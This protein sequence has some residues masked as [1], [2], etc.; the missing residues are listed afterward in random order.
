[1]TQVIECNLV[2]LEV[3]T[4]MTLACL[5]HYM[6]LFSQSVLKVL[7]FLYEVHKHLQWLTAAVSAC[8]IL[9]LYSIYV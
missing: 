4:V 1:M 9:Y 8:V 5:L 2:L 6:I 7:T 3:Q